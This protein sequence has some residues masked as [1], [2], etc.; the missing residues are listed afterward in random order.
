LISREPQT[1]GQV[2]IRTK[3]F[4]VFSESDNV[5]STIIF[6]ISFNTIYFTVKYYITEVLN[7]VN[8]VAQYWITDYFLGNQFWKVGYESWS[9]ERLDLNVLPTMASCKMVM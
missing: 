2:H 6:F 5:I 9:L 3:K 4:A 1:T 7:L 8:V